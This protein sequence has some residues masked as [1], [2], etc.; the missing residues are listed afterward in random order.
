MLNLTDRADRFYIMLDRKAIDLALVKVGITSD[1]LKNRIHAYRTS[2]PFLML[3]AV[4]EI[5]KNFELKAVEEMFFDYLRKEKGYEHAFGE[6]VIV[7][8]AEDIEAIQELGFRFFGKLFYRT[9]NIEF[10]R[11]QV[12]NLWDYKKR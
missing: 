7:D 12:R 8:N 3:V 1:T 2:N 6:W 5:R 9:K 11:E 4:S 10:C